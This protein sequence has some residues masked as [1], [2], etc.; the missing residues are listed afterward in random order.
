MK[1]THDPT[2][3][4]WRGGGPTS[5][6]G[7]KK[8]SSLSSLFTNPAM[9]PPPHNPLPLTAAAANSTQIISCNRKTNFIKVAENL[10]LELAEG[11]GIG[12]PEK[13]SGGEGEEDDD[14][15][16]RYNGGQNHPL[17]IQD[18]KHV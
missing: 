13:T 7:E 9:D 10:S 12:Q 1:P 16:N 18:W 15:G 17:W 2:H 3:D 5:A 8:S 6:A 4:H 11:I 14:A